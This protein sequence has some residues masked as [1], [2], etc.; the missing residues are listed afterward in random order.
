MDNTTPDCLNDATDR[1]VAQDGGDPFSRQALNLVQMAPRLESYIGDTFLLRLVRP[2][3]EVEEER[4]WR[5]VV[6][7]Y[8]RNPSFD[9]WHLAGAGIRGAL[10]RWF[11]NT[12]DW[13]TFFCSEFIVAS[14]KVRTREHPYMYTTYRYVNQ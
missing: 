9:V 4:L 12:E 7:E 1:I 10:P 2:L 14:L 13:S 8:H 6:A 3:T 11:S 5:F